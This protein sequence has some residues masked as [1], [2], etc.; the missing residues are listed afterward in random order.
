EEEI[1]NLQRMHVENEK[2]ALEV[3]NSLEENI[4]D[5]QKAKAK[6]E[7]LNTELLKEV[8]L[9]KVF[10]DKEQEKHRQYIKQS[11]ELQH[12]LKLEFNEVKK[13]YI[14]T[15]ELHA[16]EMARFE[17]K[18]VE[19]KLQIQEIEE[20][21]TQEVEDKKQEQEHLLERIEK[22]RK[23]VAHIREDHTEQTKKLKT[24]KQELI[25]KETQYTLEK[26]E[27]DSRSVDLQKNLVN[28][29]EAFLTL[30]EL[31]RKMLDEEK[32]K[33]KVLNE[34]VQGYKIKLEEENKEREREQA[35]Y[36]EQ[37]FMFEKTM[38]A[39][40][41]RLLRLEEK[42]LEQSK[43]EEQKR[44]ALE[45]EI[46]EKTRTLLNLNRK[47]EKEKEVSEEKREALEET[48]QNNEELL[49]SY[50][51]DYQELEL[52]LVSREK[53]LHTLVTDKAALAVEAKENIENLEN[54]LALE[55]SNHT[56]INEKYNQLVKTEKL[57]KENYEKRVKEVEFNLKSL[58]KGLS[59]SKEKLQ[60]YESSFKH[61]EEEIGQIRKSFE[62]K[63]ET[64]AVLDAKY[65][66]L[67]EINNRQKQYLLNKE[68]DEKE[69]N[70]KWE[71][72]QEE[73]AKVYQNN[74]ASLKKEI[75]DKESMYQQIKVKI[76]SLNSQLNSYKHENT[77]TVLLHE[78][79]VKQLKADIETLKENDKGETSGVHSDILDCI[80]AGESKESIAKKFAIPV[81]KVEL[82][83]K[84]DKI[85]RVK[86]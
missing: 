82:M 28:E 24:L 14:E 36:E 54:T 6:I 47:Y 57:N 32:N 55:K 79:E 76:L 16:D 72:M 71:I 74:I 7:V 40:Q 38:Q 50:V 5:I 11:N 81:K 85:K 12:S 69:N 21:H 60:S 86:Q 10:I 66:D 52:A 65:N 62:D 35:E 49:N 42:S 34:Q 80:H 17:K 30:K 27:Y 75:T 15:K 63:N 39:D 51:L 46:L 19:K 43:K 56:H 20:K 41:K 23:N 8:N 4:E 18:L 70:S 59:Q 25:Q 22:E 3:K 64:Y 45:E 37:V 31:H 1:G 61:K 83:I 44:T 84:F 77:E 58:Q 67:K 9:K 29:K 68:N 13:I 53:E 26:K 78:L 48:V 73:K 33:K 2:K